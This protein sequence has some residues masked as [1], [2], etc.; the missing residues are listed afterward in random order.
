[1]ALGDGTGWDEALPADTT[2]AS[3]IDDYNRDLRIG[4]GD[5]LGKEHIH[6]ADASVGGEHKHIT[7]QAL[8]AFPT[9]SPAAT[10]IASVFS[11]LVGT[12]HELFFR[13]KDGQEIQ[14]TSDGDI[15]V[16]IPTPTLFTTGM[17]MLWS[18]AEVDI[19]SGWHLC[20][21]T[22]STPN[23]TDK[24]VVGAGSA[25]A[26]GDTGG[27]NTHTLSISEI[28]AHTHTKGMNP[29]SCG[30]AGDAIPGGCVTTTNTGSAGGGSAH[31]NRPPYYALCYIM[32]I[33][34]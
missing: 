34:V 21:G 17:I 4:I 11:K 7:L 14:I 18:G 23:L 28:P 29:R 5:R 1:M 10:Q 9:L 24:F 6:P 30:D 16:V 31:E 25:Y 33:T 15:N 19:P 2:V 13:N 12:K 8:A 3:N 27:E 20:D 32:K 26:V 22:A